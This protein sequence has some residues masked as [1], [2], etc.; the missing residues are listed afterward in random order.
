M[1]VQGAGHL[2][3]GIVHVEHVVV[4]DG[5]QVGKNDE[6]AGGEFGAHV[7]VRRNQTAGAAAKALHRE[8][9]TVALVPN[10]VDAI[11][12]VARA[13][14]GTKQIPCQLLRQL[15]GTIGQGMVLQ[16]VFGHGLF[17]QIRL[18]QP[19]LRVQPRWPR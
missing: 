2:A 19:Q 14:Q 10:H 13:T 6:F 7:G 4:G 15:G 3:Q 17:R 12:A 8:G 11:T 5:W 16:I 18:G 9:P 1:I